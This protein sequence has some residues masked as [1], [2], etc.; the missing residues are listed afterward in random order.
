[1][2]FIGDYSMATT[3]PSGIFNYT[4]GSA[5]SANSV[6]VEKGNT[7]GDVINSTEEFK[8]ERVSTNVNVQ[9]DTTGYSYTTW[10]EWNGEGRTHTNSNGEVFNV[11]H[12]HYVAGISTQYYP[13][14]EIPKTGIATY[15][16]T[17][18]GDYTLN[19]NTS[20]TIER[21]AIG[22]TITL[23]AN[24]GSQTISGNLSATRNGSAW[25]SANFGS[26]PIN[27]SGNYSSE[28]ENLTV[29][30]G[31]SG[32]ISGNFYGPNAEETGGRWWSSWRL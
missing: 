24:F 9:T 15:H 17:L 27:N 6:R 19:T 20:N 4:S 28:N 30:G 21:N 26:T 8:F 32:R 25:A 3:S 11:D 29:T 1:M 7:I 18:Q 5:E 2:P 14:G 12:G 23:N 31:G 16:G 13:G 10:G 22:G